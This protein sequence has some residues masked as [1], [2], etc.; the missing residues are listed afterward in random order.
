MGKY[1]II[2]KGIGAAAAG[3]M[4]YDAGRAGVVN[5]AKTQKCYTADRLPDQYINSMRMND[6]SAIG[7]KL[8]KGLFKW[9]MDDNIG[10]FFSSI[11]GFFSGAGT[12]L[13]SNVIPAA[14]ATGAIMFKKAGK[15]CGLGLLA[16][17]AKYLLYDV[18]NVGKPK[19][20]T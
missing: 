5:S 20:I 9:Q 12:S 16:C 13:V 17:G 14:L 10:E 4:L 6:N 19:Q 18:L 1:S 2:S 3:M 15:F 11:G 7:N 8:K